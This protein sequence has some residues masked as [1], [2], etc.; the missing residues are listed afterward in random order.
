[1]LIHGSKEPGVTANFFIG[2]GHLNK[3]LHK[4]T[5]QSKEKLNDSIG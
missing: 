4:Q 5:T 2:Y 1:M 3:S